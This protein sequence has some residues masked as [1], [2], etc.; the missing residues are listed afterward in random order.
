MRVR[1]VLRSGRALLQ[2]WPR[3][4]AP[5]IAERF[6]RPYSMPPLRKRLALIRPE[7]VRGL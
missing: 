5:V 3:M 6:G 4:P 1:A 7:Y 2:E